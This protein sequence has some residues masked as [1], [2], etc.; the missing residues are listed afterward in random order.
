[1]L[2]R[3]NQSNGT[4]GQLIPI[5]RQWTTEHDPQ[6]ENGRNL[7][8]FVDGPLTPLQPTHHHHCLIQSI[9]DERCKRIKR[10]NGE[11]M[12]KITKRT[13]H[14]SHQRT[15]IPTQPVR[16]RFSTNIQE[17]STQELRIHPSLQYGYNECTYVRIGWILILCMVDVAGMR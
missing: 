7:Q 16:T 1:M 2:Q 10:N 8:I 6:D 3:D 9:P 14:D 12:T 4:K 15:P 5:E 17:I 11:T 13:A